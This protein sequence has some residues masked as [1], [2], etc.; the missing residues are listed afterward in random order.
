[1]FDHNQMRELAALKA[2]RY[3]HNG[4]GGGFV[5]RNTAKAYYDARGFQNRFAETLHFAR[6][7][8]ADAAKAAQSNFHL[9]CLCAREGIAADE[10]IPF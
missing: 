9:A 5:V 7:S 3:Q 4:G 8:F 6:Q 1:M 10:A 2:D